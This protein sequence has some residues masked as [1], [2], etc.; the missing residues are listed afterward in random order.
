MTLTNSEHCGRMVQ[1]VQPSLL[2]ISYDMESALGKIQ[3]FISRMTNEA[4]LR[5]HSA[6]YFKLWQMRKHAIVRCS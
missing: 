3:G 1:I 6:H 5:S 4:N 2:Q